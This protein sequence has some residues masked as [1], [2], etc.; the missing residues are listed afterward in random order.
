M[1]IYID[2]F[3]PDRTALN[4]ASTEQELAAT[5]LLSM[6][7]DEASAKVRTG[8]PVDDDEDYAL[9]VWAG[10]IA[11]KTVIEGI[12][13]D[14]KNLDG[15]KMPAGIEKYVAGARLDET[16]SAIYDGDNTSSHG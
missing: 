9:P 15:I 6:N 4:R 14:P 5:K 11:F 13:S 8:Q 3:V 7:I 1:D 10:V 16:L 12:H 2:R